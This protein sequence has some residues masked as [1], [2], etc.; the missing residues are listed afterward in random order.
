[1]CLTCFFHHSLGNDPV[2]EPLVRTMDS[3]TT[4]ILGK[5]NDRN[6]SY[7]GGAF[8]DPAIW[9][10]ALDKDDPNLEDI[11]MGKYIDDIGKA[12]FVSSA[13]EFLDDYLDFDFD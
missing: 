5:R 6:T 12:G 8:D 7:L 9:Y 10:Q 1:M 4:L 11:I 13:K 2:G 3:F